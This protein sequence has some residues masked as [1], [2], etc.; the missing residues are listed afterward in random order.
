MSNVDKNRCWE[1][2]PAKRPDIDVL[3]TLFNKLVIE[4][5]IYDDLGRDFWFTYF[6]NKVSAPNKRRI[7]LAIVCAD[8][9][10]GIF[11]EISSDSNNQFEAS[12]RV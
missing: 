10:G 2:D 5:L 12:F 3:T 8:Y 11:K 7:H 4:A 6:P 1:E 9:L